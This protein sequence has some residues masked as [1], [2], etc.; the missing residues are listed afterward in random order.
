MAKADA[1]ALAA[2]GFKVFPIATGKKAPPLWNDWPTHAAASV[3]EDWPEDCNVGVHCDGLIVLDIDTGKGG[4]ESLAALELLYDLPPTRTV[5]TPSGGRH[6]YYAGPAVGN[7]V[8]KL[9]RGIDVRSRGGY[10]VAPGSR[11]DAGAY[12]WIDERAVAPAPEWLVAKLGTIAPKKGT[13]FP[14]A[15]APEQVVTAAGGVLLTLAP[16]IEGEG[17]DVQTF[18]VA[19]RMRDLGLSATQAY[20]LMVEHWNPRCSPP[21]DPEDLRAKVDNAYRY[22]QNA[23]GAKAALPADFPVIAESHK[24]KV[25]PGAIRLSEFAKSES[26]GAGYVVKGLLQRRSYA[27]VYGAPGEGK[28]FV[29]LDMAYHVAAGKP[30]MEKKVHAGPVLYLAFEGTGGLVKRAQA[31]RQ[32]YGEDDVPLF[33][34]GAAFDLRAP[35]GRAALGEVLADLP[36]KPVLI[37]VDT[38]ARALMGGDENSAQDV[39][40]FNSAVAALI[41]STGACVC[42]IHHSGKDKTKGAR[43]SSALLGALDTEIEVDSGNI[44]ATKQRDVEAG[45]P[46]GFKLVP[47]VVG[48]DDDGDEQTSCV[49]EGSAAAPQKRTRLSGNTLR[50]FQTLC[51]KWPSNEPVHLDSWKE[52]CREFLPKAGVSQRFFDIK[53]KLL[54]ADMIAEDSQ[55]RIT[56]RLE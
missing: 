26:R 27:A 3:S 8:G 48:V 44:T 13:T 31:L 55:G 56:R 52:A 42:I 9:G 46:I 37:A 19:C 54:E 36:A 15:D 49:V 12:E 50:G 14:V 28:T 25:R 6:L 11:T 20:D 32:R 33:I 10:V 5:R 34:S 47:M 41:E 7:S 45:E 17:G 29:A 21:W 51:D 18:V 38:F 30:W 35:E 24:R 22:G 23:P 16:A 40:A 43:G 53:R 39:G 2:Q 1:A 4:D